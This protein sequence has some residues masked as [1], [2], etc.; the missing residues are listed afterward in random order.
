MSDF[1]S[2]IHFFIKKYL[3]NNKAKTI[4]DEN[5]NDLR[6]NNDYIYNNAYKEEIIKK[7][8]NLKILTFMVGFTDSLSKIIYSVCFFYFKVEDLDFFPLLSG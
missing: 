3:T 7:S 1:L 8:K 4:I 6:N 5:K 2:L